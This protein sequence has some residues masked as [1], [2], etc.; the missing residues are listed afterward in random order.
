MVNIEEI[1][2]KIAE[3]KRERCFGERENALEKKK[4]EVLLK[5]YGAHGRLPPRGVLWKQHFGVG[6]SLPK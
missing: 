2:R 4:K 5:A 6:Q 1:E 3:E